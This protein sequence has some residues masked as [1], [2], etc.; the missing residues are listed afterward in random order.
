MKRY[1]NAMFQ[2]ANY[3][4]DSFWVGSTKVSVTKYFDGAIYVKTHH[5]YDD[6]DY[7]W[8]MSTDGTIFKVCLG[9]QYVTTFDADEGD[10][11]EVALG[12]IELDKRANIKPKMMHN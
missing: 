10:F 4:T 11:K 8:A 6:A 12:L 9:R 3:T 2:D 1:I 5:P 7:H